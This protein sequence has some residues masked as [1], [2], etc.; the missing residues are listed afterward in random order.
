MSKS[1]FSPEIRLFCG[2]II[3]AACLFIGS[4]ALATPPQIDP[5]GSFGLP[6]KCIYVDFQAPLEIIDTDGDTVIVTSNYGIPQLTNIYIDAYGTSHWLGNIEFYT[7]EYCG[8][9]FDDSLIITADDQHGEVDTLRTRPVTFVGSMAVSLGE[10]IEIWPGQV[11]SMPVYLNTDS[12]FSIGGFEIAVECSEA[13]L[14]VTGAQLGDQLIGNEYYFSWTE[15]PFGTST[16]KFVFIVNPDLS[17]SDID[18]DTPLMWISLELNPD[19]EYPDDFVIPV[20]FYISTP[21]Y[22]ANDFS[23]ESGFAVWHI[24]GCD[25]GRLDLQVENGSVIVHN[26]QQVLYG[27][28]NL[29][30]YAYEVGD[31]VLAYNAVLNIV[32]FN[33]NDLQREAGDVDRDNNSLTEADLDYMSSIFN[34]YSGLPPYEYDPQ[35][36]TLRI[37]SA[38]VHPGQAFDLPVYLAANDTLLGFQGYFTGASDYLIIDSLVSSGEIELNQSLVSGYPHIFSYQPWVGGPVKYFGVYYLGN[39]VGHVSPEA[40]AGEVMTI[41]MTEN[42]DFLAY[43]GCVAGEFFTPVLIG[44]QITVLDNT[45]YQY[46]PGDANMLNGAWP[47]A[48]IGSDVTYLVNFF[49][50]APANPACLIAGFYC[51]GDINGDCRVIGS[52]VTR[53]VSYF[54]GINNIESCPDYPPLWPT[55]DDCPEQAPPGWPNCED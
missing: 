28:I 9:V 22:D 6:S 46:V 52:D 49:R 23:D 25:Y 29:N 34:G 35:A 3:C 37:E 8:R 17:I 21:V 41:E 27:D 50:G 5:D 44:S 39:L 40:P 2:A 43:T 11:A 33:L 15:S 16:D 20:N 54:R 55:P 19:E 24:N 47:P 14:N 31:L 45:G 48:V 42:P 18:P 7:E 30:G 38:S 53:L 26:E 1:I 4:I 12:C 10:N 51:A 13:Y 36:D 32:D